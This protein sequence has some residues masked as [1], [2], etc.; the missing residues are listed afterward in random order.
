MGAE[1]GWGEEVPQGSWEQSLLHLPLGVAQDRARDRW[2]GGAGGGL[3]VQSQ[4]PAPRTRH[5]LSPGK[6]VR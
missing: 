4:A 3:Q 6:E 5:V 1:G 2:L